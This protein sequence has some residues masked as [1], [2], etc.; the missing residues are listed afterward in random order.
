[1]QRNDQWIWLPKEVVTSISN[2]GITFREVGRETHTISPDTP[3]NIY[4]EMGWKGTTQC[5]YVRLTAVANGRQGG[6]IFTDEV[7]VE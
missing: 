1:M 4:S 6:W 7:I 2:D 3:D 5:R